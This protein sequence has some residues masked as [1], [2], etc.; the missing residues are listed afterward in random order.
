MQNVSQA[1]K[2]NQNKQLVSESFVEISLDLTDP[3][4]SAN[5]T[6]SS[7]MAIAL[8]N[9]NGIID[10]AYGQVPR[11]V[12]LE[13]NL[14]LLDGSGKILPDS[15]RDNATVEDAGYVG[16]VTSSAN[17][18]FSLQP[19]ITLDFP[20]VY[21]TTI[22]GATITWGKAVDEYATEFKVTAYN[23]D[24]VVSE[25]EVNDNTSTVSSLFMDISNYN[26]IEIRVVK[27]CLPYHRARVE[28]ISLGAKKVYGKSDIFSYTNSQEMDV[29]VADLPKNTVAFKVNNM[30]RAYDFRNATGLSK[31]LIEKQEMRVRYGYSLSDGI[32][33][34]DGGVFYLSNWE[35]NENSNC[36]SFEGVSLL[37]SLTMVYEQDVFPSSER[38]LYDL[39]ELV[40]TYANIPLTRDKKVRWVIDDNLKDVKTLSVLPADTVANCL[41]L[42]ANAGCCSLYCDRQGIIHL[43][44]R[45]LSAGD[46]LVNKNNSFIKPESIISPPIRDITI[47]YD[48]ASAEADRVYLASTGLFHVR[49]KDLWKFSLPYRYKGA[50][51]QATDILLEVQHPK[52]GTIIYQSLGSSRAQFHV[53]PT[54]EENTGYL[55]Y[56]YRVKVTGKITTVDSAELV[57]TVSDDITKGENISISNSLISS[58]DHAMDVAEW[59]RDSVIKRQTINLSWR[60]D[61]RVDVYDVIG[62][63]D[64]YGDTSVI[65]T[66]LDYS[67]N[68]AFKATAEGRVM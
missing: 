33:W 32:E 57:L 27:W 14:W 42:I 18:S 56:D 21:A 17:R 66:K 19:I 1:W 30:D 4:A 64:S 54:F 48:A 12:T 23:G 68:G 29:I 22:P 40:L 34:I 16:Y 52:N 6:A 41:Q 20:E 13:P 45:D 35:A 8:S 59:T 2:D 51:V 36:I 5:A 61:P 28:N 11:Y 3:N 65:L 39:A 55:T 37:E 58:A 63:V 47:T 44:K 62:V 25:L 9:M 26:K 31:Y 15:V 67:Y 43:E 53:V 38:S 10:E 49:K 50:P 24:I 60:P 46:Y 7:N